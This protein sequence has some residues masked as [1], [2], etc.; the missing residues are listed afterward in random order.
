MSVFEKLV[1]LLQLVMSVCQIIIVFPFFP[2]AFQA[3]SE[4]PREP[5]SIRAVC[6]S[7]S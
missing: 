2:A 6:T 3:E 7:S 4:E 5:S 1:F